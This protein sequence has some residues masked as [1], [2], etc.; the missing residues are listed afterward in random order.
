MVLVNEGSASASEIFAGAMKDHKRGVLVGG[1]TF[2]K[3]SVQTP[4]R[5]RDRSYLKLTTARYYTPS[6]YS[7]QKIKGKRDYGLVPD[8]LVEM[9]T[10]ENAGLIKFW[11][12]E[13]IRKQD[14]TKK[15]ES[16]FKD[17]QLEAGIEVIRAA[18]EK[19]EPKVTLRELDKEKEEDK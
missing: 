1:K 14:P 4:F 7:V 10:K 6:G 15:I 3:G 18:L 19:R 12:E 11:N 17:I 5:M 9:N 13:R 2:G 8:Y 16:D